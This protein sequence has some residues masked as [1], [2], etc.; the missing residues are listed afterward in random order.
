MNYKDDVLIPL[1][2]H[3]LSKRDYREMFIFLFILFLRSKWNYKGDE[4]YFPQCFF[5]LTY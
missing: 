3:Y 2:I 5:F 4:K 1:Y